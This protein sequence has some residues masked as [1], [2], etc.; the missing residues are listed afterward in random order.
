MTLPQAF[1]PALR[2]PADFMYRGQ[3]RNA[4][5]IVCV[6]SAS[7]LKCVCVWGGGG[8]EESVTSGRGRRQ[9]TA[10]WFYRF[11]RGP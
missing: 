1:Y 3:H 7:A 9:W 11:R 5:F 6:P 10:G 4:D 2:S 8:G